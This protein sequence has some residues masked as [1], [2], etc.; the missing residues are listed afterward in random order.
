M[1]G[2]FGGMNPFIAPWARPGHRGQWRGLF[3]SSPLCVFVRGHSVDDDS[4]AAGAADANDVAGSSER[5]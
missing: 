5:L 1:Q 4:G 3:G 2:N